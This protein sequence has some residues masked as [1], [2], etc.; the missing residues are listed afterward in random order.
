MINGNV[1]VNDFIEEYEERLYEKYKLYKTTEGPFDEK[2]N[3]AHKQWKLIL[4]FIYDD[5]VDA[6]FTLVQFKNAVDYMGAKLAYQDQDAEFA[7]YWS[8]VTTMYYHIN[9]QIVR[10]LQ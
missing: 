7:E 2:T 3:K 9:E 4:Q 10:L 5:K 8:A 6:T 1:F